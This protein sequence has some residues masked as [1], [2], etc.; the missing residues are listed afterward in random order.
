[1][2]TSSEY[3]SRYAVGT[4]TRGESS[5][6]NTVKVRLYDLNL[7]PALERFLRESRLG[8]LS[9]SGHE[10]EFAEYTLHRP[11]DAGEIAAL[12][13]LILWYAAY[14]DVDGRYHMNGDVLTNID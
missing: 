7:L 8:T 6:P 4:C 9:A 5:H 1:M 12:I 11:K 13:R 3:E 2:A 10:R 14:G